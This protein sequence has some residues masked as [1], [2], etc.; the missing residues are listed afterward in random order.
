M[1]AELGRRKLYDDGLVLLDE[2]IRAEP[3]N[4]TAL[5]SRAALLT[6]KQEWGAVISTC[7]GLLKLD[8]RNARCHFYK[9]I[10]LNSLGQSRAALESLDRAIAANP[11]LW[12]ALFYQGNIALASG[13]F[14]V[15]PISP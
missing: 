7:E 9:G 15:V 12:Q 13:N 6:S 8:P 1:E 10:A 5:I 11:N 3:N 4:S 2:V 14:I